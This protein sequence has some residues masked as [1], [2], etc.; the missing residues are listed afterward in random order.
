MRSS[1][2][3][4]ITG[5]FND[6]DADTTH[7]LPSNMNAAAKIQPRILLVDD[8]Q[9]MLGMQSRILQNMGYQ[10]VFCAGSAQ[11]ALQFLERGS[12]EVDVLVC[13]LNMPGMDGIEFLQTLNRGKFSGSVIVLSGEGARIMH[14]V[15]KL[16][17][18][19]RLV[20]LGAIEKPANRAALRSLLDSWRPVA[21]SSVVR[22]VPTFTE[23]ELRAAQQEGQW[24]LHYQPKVDLRT[25]M[26]A[27]ME[28]LVRW[29]HPQLGLVPPDSF[30]GLAEECGFMDE[31]TDWVLCE[32]M[33]QLA[34][35]NIEDLR[36]QMAVNISMY[37]LRAPGFSGRAG[38]VA[39]RTCASPQDVILEVTESRLM[40]P[41]PAPLEN[42]VRLRLQRFGLSIDDF[43]TGH[44]SL[45]QLRDVPFTELKVDR[46]F[47]QGARHNQV[48][49]PILEGSIGIA[50]RMGMKSVGEGVETEDDWHLLREIGC[51]L[52]QGWF[53]GRPMLPVKVAEWLKHWR[54]Q[55]LLMAEK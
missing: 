39:R 8:D 1:N 22:P 9:F 24:L 18:G 13:D 36:I 10:V 4:T 45:A 40:S 23:A 27:G 46:S 7:Q 50:K 16:L 20:I 3:D 29:D 37:S 25:G 52:A 55:H 15:Q 32:A 54:S 41:S 42:L 17:D 6:P 28:A 31:L 30:I 47:V 19:S 5:K 21:P 33:Q 51:D 35:W 11:A 38:E 12:R 44:S 48:T 43:G 53:I 34:Q 14:T 26:L 2:H 49:R